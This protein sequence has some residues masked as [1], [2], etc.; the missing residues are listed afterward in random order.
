M[1]KKPEEKARQNIDILLED[2]GWVIQDYEDLN[3]GESLGDAI[4]NFI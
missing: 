1:A 2:A 4:V 3:L